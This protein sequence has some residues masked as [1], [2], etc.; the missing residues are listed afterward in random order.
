MNIR[1]AYNDWSHQYDTNANRT[2]DM[3]AKVLRE[4]LK[5]VVFD[6][7]LEI[8][9]GTGKN[10]EWLVQHAKH[11]TAVD[12]S[13]GMLAKAREKINAGNVRFVQADILQPW[14]FRQGNYDL[15]T[16]SLVLEHVEHLAPVLEEAAAILPPGDHVYIGELHP[17]KQYGGTK[18]RFETELG[19]Q[20]V[21]CFDHHVS[22]FLQAARAA[23]FE[24]VHLGEHFDEEE[25]TGPPRIL[26]LLL[27]K[28]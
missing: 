2:R 27:R 5:D 21:T 18:A 11:I 13:E 26:S 7:V 16:F 14:T 17:F 20:L 6:R 23:D 10:T 9:C 24:L 15:V 3:E 22:D 25:R 12:L 8:G 4:V 28:G 1:S 19:T